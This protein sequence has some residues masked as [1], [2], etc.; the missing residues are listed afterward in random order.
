MAQII[1]AGME[2]SCGF[3]EIC[4]NVANENEIISTVVVNV[5]W[6]PAEVAL[7]SYMLTKPRDTWI[8]LLLH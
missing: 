8:W 3:F 4:C 2:L 1:P 7:T 5:F 6:I